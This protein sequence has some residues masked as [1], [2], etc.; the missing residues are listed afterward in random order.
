[1]I[2][3]DFVNVGKPSASSFWFKRN[4]NNLRFMA[5]LLALAIIG[6]LGVQ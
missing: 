2:G 4:G 5:G 6:S 3:R 1:M